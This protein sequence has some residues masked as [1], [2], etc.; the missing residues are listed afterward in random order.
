MIF[1][2]NDDGFI[3]MRNDKILN[4]IPFDPGKAGGFGAIFSVGKNRKN[5]AGLREFNRI[6]YRK[7]V[8]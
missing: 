3:L 4:L 8:V 2:L 6:R 1:S 7:G 5:M